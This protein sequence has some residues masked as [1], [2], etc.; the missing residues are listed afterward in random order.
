MLTIKGPTRIIFA[1]GDS[2]SLAYHGA[3]RGY[4]QI[5]FIPDPNPIPP[6]TETDLQTIFY[7]LGTYEVPAQETSYVCSSFPVPAGNLRKVTQNNLK[8]INKLYS[9]MQ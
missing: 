5:S 6:P 8:A 3:N 4:T 7:S 2:D 9:L 1:Y